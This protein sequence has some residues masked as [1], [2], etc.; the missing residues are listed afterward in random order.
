MSPHHFH[1][2]MINPSFSPDHAKNSSTHQHTREMEE[3]IENFFSKLVH[4]VF[5][6]GR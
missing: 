1:K 5:R 3:K 2:Q 4:F 6:K